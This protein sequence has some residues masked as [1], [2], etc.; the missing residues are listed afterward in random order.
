MLNFMNM[1]Y[2]YISIYRIRKLANAKK[3]QE[4]MLNKSRKKIIT[5]MYIH[6]YLYVIYVYEYVCMYVCT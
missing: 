5:K 3:Q 4:L 6:M 1:S 2:R